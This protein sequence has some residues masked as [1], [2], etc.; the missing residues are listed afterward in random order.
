M[1]FVVAFAFSFVQPQLVF[2]SFD[3][4]GW[5]TVQFGIVVGVYGIAMAGGQLL[6]GHISDRLGRK[7]VIFTGLIAMLP[8]YAAVILSRNYFVILLGAAV[9]G[10]GDALTS[11]ARNAAYLDMTAPAHRARISGIKDSAFSL[12]G[13]LGPLAVAGAAGLMRPRVVFA[14]GG[15]TLLGVAFLFLVLYREHT[16]ADHEALSLGWQVTEERCLAAQA[17][18]RGL[19]LDAR[20]ARSEMG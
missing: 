15:A 1:D 11:P 13:V 12:G 17:A 14:I 9:S 4:L 7:P 2:Y 8:M 16:R 6:L 19:A 3:Q 10:L 18:L 20:R 5:S